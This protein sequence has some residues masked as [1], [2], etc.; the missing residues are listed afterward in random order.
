MMKVPF[1]LPLIDQDVINEVNDALINTGWL[2]TGPKVQ[3][4]EEEIKKI[5][6]AREVLCVNSWN[7]GTTLALKWW[8]I[9]PGDEIIIPAYTYSA[10]ALTV[11][12]LGAKAVMVDVEDDFNISVQKIKSAITAKTKCI[13]PV[14]I[15][16]YPCDYDEIFELVEDPAIK[17]LFIPESENQ[18]RL[19][20]ILV[21][22]D[23]AHSIGALYKKRHSGAL[24][25][26]SVFSFHSVKNIT[27]G[28]GGAVCLNVPGL[29]NSDIKA[30]LKHFYL[31]GQTKSALDKTRTGS[32][33][34]DIVSQGMKGNMPDICASIGLAQIRKYTT[35]LLP[36]RKEIFAR[37]NSAFQKFEWA[38][39]PPHE[40]DIKKSS[41]HLYMLRIR[42]ISEYQRDK[43]IEY[44]SKRGVGVGVHYIP[45]AMFSLFKNKG[46]NI[47]DYPNTF[48]NYEREIS[49]PIYNGLTVDQID[50]VI[51]TV[52]NAYTD[53]ISYS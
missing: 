13:I 6:S 16:G 44:V 53:V 37:Y 4:F 10:T 23:S 22:A 19:N 32:W 49:L 15:G 51:D 26:I 21:L 3:A 25:D 29:S 33:R 11:M 20:R 9:K 45:M 2:T 47:K 1:C 52:I 30:F 46:Y 12:N 5:T 43:M 28:E 38:V 35:D 41:C 42:S 39:L 17:R 50:Y 31:Y 8:G 24:A 14:D 36:E 48:Q 7:S 34:Y 18:E 40:T 27:T